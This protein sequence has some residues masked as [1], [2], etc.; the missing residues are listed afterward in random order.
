MGTTVAVLDRVD[1]G[2]G[3]RSVLTGL[4]LQVGAGRQLALLGPSGAGKSTVMRL[5]TGQLQPDAGT[6]SFPGGRP[7]MGWAS[8]DPLLF[9][10]LTVTENIRLGGRFGANEPVSDARVAELLEVLHLADVAESYPAQL[11]G[12]QAQRVSLARAIATRPGL[13]LLDEPFSALDP[14][15]RHDLQQWL[16]AVLDEEGLSSVIVSHDIDEAL[17]LADHIVLLGRDGRVRQ[18]WD[19]PQR[20]E[21]HHAALAHPLRTEIRRGY[22]PV[23][24]A[25]DSEFSGVL[26]D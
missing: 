2:Y 16:R 15:T 23:L 10:W 17:V 24:E 12:G 18:E 1:A 22:G 14:A 25:D 5:L 7:R 11:S 3:P 20:A 8:Q 6:L 21:H 9:D 26:D 4:S 13:L 19:N